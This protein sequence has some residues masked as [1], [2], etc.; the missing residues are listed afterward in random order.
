MIFFTDGSRQSLTIDGSNGDCANAE[1]DATGW[2]IRELAI[3]L[4]K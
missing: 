4:E 3:T 1:F 2:R